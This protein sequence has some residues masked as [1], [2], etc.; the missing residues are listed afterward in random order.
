LET[1]RILDSL[2]E[3]WKS[4]IE[5]T[6][7]EIAELSRL[8]LEGM[9][10]VKAAQT[11]ADPDVLARYNAWAEGSTTKMALHGLV[12]LIEAKIGGGNEAAGALGGI[13]QEA[14]TPLMS[15]YLEEHGIKSDSADYDALMQLGATLA[16]AAIGA[17]ADGTQGAATAANTAYQGVTNN[18]ILHKQASAIMQ[19]YRGCV[20]SGKTVTQCKTEQTNAVNAIEQSNL[21]V[22]VDCIDNPDKSCRAGLI[23]GLSILGS[24]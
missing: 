19:K 11:L 13:T 5:L 22:I 9:T 3:G 10:G 4:S 1:D 16:G 12:G 8:D 14:L 21:K 24:S 23:A 20:S 2:L 17:M 6:A 15:Q 18:T 7:S